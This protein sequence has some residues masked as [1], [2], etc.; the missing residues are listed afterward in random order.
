MKKT[1]IG[2][3]IFLLLIAAFL[4]FSSAQ[5]QMDIEKEREKLSQEITNK[6]GKES[7]EISNKISEEVSANVAKEVLIEIEQSLPKPPALPDYDSLNNLKLLTL[8]KNFESWTPNAE[9]VNDKVAEVNIHQKGELAKGYLF[10]EASL[11]KKA[12]S[13]WESIYIKINNEGGHLF[14]SNS[15]PVPSSGNTELLFALDDIY[16]LSSVPY[17]ERRTPSNLSWFNYFQ[18]GKIINLITFISSLRPAL[19]NE[20]SLYYGCIKDGECVLSLY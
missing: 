3:N 9:I 4:L 17:S 1:D 16:Y 8:V 2:I 12:L 11:D 5:Q 20:I 19:I 13:K 6:I 18:D 15:L 10:I 7:E 14:R